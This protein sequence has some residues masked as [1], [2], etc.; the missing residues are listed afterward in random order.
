M[1]EYGSLI[2]LRCF[3]YIYEVKCEGTSEIRFRAV[4]HF[5]KLASYQ[6][7]A[8]CSNTAEL[9]R[10]RKFSASWTHWIH[11]SPSINSAWVP[12]PVQCQ[13]PVVCTLTLICSHMTPSMSS[14]N[15]SPRTC[16]I[17]FTHVQQVSNVL[18]MLE[19]LY[20]L[21]LHMQ[22]NCYLRVIKV[23]SNPSQ[24]KGTLE[25]K[26][27]AVKDKSEACSPVDPH[28]R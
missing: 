5:Y 23:V 4:K 14:T 21:S 11:T 7:L 25:Q 18:D 20:I 19:L 12:G 2:F 10:R 27:R 17:Q 16:I 26:A 1:H 28:G 8:Y 15:W 13:I 6:P 22:N 24:A 9:C 3:I